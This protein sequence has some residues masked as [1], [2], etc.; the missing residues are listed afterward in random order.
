MTKHDERTILVTG[1]TGTVGSEVVKQLASPSVGYGIIK[2]AVHSQD[3]SNKFEGYD[4]VEIVNLD[5]RRQET[6]ARSLNNV[7]KIFLLTLPALDMT[8]IYSNLVKEA[9]KNDV[10][11]IVKLSVM[12]ADAEPGNTVVRLHRQEERIIEESGIP[13]SF[14]HPNAFMQNFVNYYGRTIKN[15]NAFYLPAGDGKISFVDARDV[16]AVAVRVI[17][18][19]GSQHENKIYEITGQEALSFG[20]AA[21]ILSKENGRTISYID[22]PEED[23]RKGLE[24]MGMEDWLI[25]A[26]MAAYR[27]WKGGY[28]SKMT[29]VVKHIT[30]RKPILFAQFAKDY[31]EALR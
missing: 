21:E 2:A 3:K 18:E 9:K 12:G 26:I 23:A 30:G 7:D 31:A 17:T 4:S 20:Q 15:E 25:E 1:S 6:I 14:L 29:D 24:E 19:N 11:Y 8:D 22:I 27:S 28:M 16:A 5:Y 13:F 10:K